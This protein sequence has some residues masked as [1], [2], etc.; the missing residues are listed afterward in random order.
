MHWALIAEI[1]ESEA[2]A[3]VKTMQKIA[4]LIV[5]VS[6]AIII[7][8]AFF[9][10]RLIMA[11]IKVVVENLR[12]LSQGE[13]D[14]TQRLKMNCPT[15]S[16]VMDCSEP[17]CRS[18]G[19]NGMCWEISGTMSNNPDCIEVT[20]GKMK[21]CIDCK[22][23]KQSNYDELQELSSN[24]NNFILK[25]QH[26]FKEVV[27]GVVTISS[28]TTELS[29]IAEQMSG[30]AD[31]VSNQSNSVATAAEEMSVNMDS[32]AA[33]TEETTTNMNIVASAAEEMT[34]TIADVNANTE[35]ASKVTGEAVK[36]ALSATE[37]VQQLGLAASEISKVT[38]V[39]DLNN[40]GSD[41]SNRTNRP[42]RIP[43]T[44]LLPVRGNQHAAVSSTKA[45]FIRL[46]PEHSIL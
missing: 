29:A 24:F 38:E 26:M 10:L 42:F 3:S 44:N 14:L 31:N 11:P 5:L 39:I 46:H 25:L 7:M 37:K 20:S 36:E 2:M 21:D 9:M 16:D 4:A 27:H 17:G 41:L 15:C 18:Y 28:A 12:E 35:E 33:A 1:D 19:K 8:V 34:A 45:I 13:G 43:D 40:S 22:V 30:S 32:V 6:A 23:Y